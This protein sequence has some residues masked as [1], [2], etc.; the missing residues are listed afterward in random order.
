MDDF[1]TLTTTDK[2]M[3]YLDKELDATDEG[4]SVVKEDKA[5]IAAIINKVWQDD[6]EAYIA[7]SWDDIKD[8]ILQQLVDKGYL[9]F[10]E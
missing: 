7:D 2:V 6:I 9:T 4:Y 1:W 5:A 3:T 10:D 8:N